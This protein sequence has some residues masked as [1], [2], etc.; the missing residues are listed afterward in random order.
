MGGRRKTESAAATSTPGV[1][2]GTAQAGSLNAR[3]FNPTPVAGGAIIDP[4]TASSATLDAS[5]AAR[6][7]VAQIKQGTLLGDFG[8]YQTYGSSHGGAASGRAGYGSHGYSKG[9]LF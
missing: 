6:R 2:P 8:N 5:A 1:G 9:G 4:G 7:R 3:S